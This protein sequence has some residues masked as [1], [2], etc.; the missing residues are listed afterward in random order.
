MDDTKLWGAVNMLEGKD[1]VQWAHKRFNKSKYNILHLSHR[2]SHYLS[3]LGDER[4][5]RSPAEKDLGLLVDGKLD[6][7][8]QCV[9]TAQ[10]VYHICIKYTIYTHIYSYIKYTICCIKRSM[11]SRIRELI[12][13]LYSA[14]VRPHLEY[15]LQT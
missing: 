7:N 12:L 5:E 14:L 3:K 4:I 9:L 2:N 8:Q 6:M 1:A 13:P 10:N 15:Y 11:A